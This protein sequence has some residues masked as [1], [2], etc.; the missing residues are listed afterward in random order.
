MVLLGVFISQSAEIGPAGMVIHT[1]QGL[2]IPPVKI[3]ESATFQSGVLIGS[4]CREGVPAE[5]CTIGEQD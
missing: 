2:Y 3:A 5:T 1:P 4:G